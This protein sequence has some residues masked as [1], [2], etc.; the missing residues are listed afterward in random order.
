MNI[1]YWKTLNLLDK[2]YL[3]ALLLISATLFFHK[4]NINSICIILFSVIWLFN[5]KKHLHKLPDKKS[6]IVFISFFMLSIYGL[7]ISENKDYA[8]KIVQR[9]LPFLI[10]PLIFNTI[11]HRKINYDYV[12]IGF[13]VFTSIASI[14]CQINNLV[15]WSWVNSFSTNDFSI[16]QYLTHHWFTYGELT[17]SIDLQPS[18]FSLYIILASIFLIEFSIDK[19]V[20][21]GVVLLLLFYFMV[22]MI[23]L[24]SKIGVLVY[25]LLLVYYFFKIDFKIKKQSKAF[26]FLFFAIC[27]SVFLFKSRFS[28]RIVELVDIFKVSK[29]PGDNSDNVKKLRVYALKAFA[30][31]P[32]E[33]IIFGQGTGDS[34]KYLD[35]YYEQNLI[36]KNTEKEVVWKLKGLHYHN[37]FVQVFAD[38]GV[39]GFICL[40]LLFY[41]M[42][43]ENK[44]KGHYL[45]LFACLLFF[46][47]DSMLIR[48][49]ALVFFVFFNLIYITEKNK[50][51]TFIHNN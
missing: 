49:K 30:E 31:Q 24:S 32:I 11:K 18:F 46:M 45:F 40:I 2:L 44:K 7:L 26:I 42:F 29:D 39:F 9:Y 25:M 43:K 16:F 17:K 48:H 47:A 33:K 10:F 36:N 1:N 6:F 51:E 5:K 28:D 37:Q 12:K 27:F 15:Y 19:K 23:Q 50:N 4:E 41:Y 22:F 34:Q 14:Y 20:K 13:I 35:G 8:L 3:I 38:T 21:K